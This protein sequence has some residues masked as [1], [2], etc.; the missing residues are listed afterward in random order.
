MRV[1][2]PGHGQDMCARTRCK[3]MQ[4]LTFGAVFTQRVFDVTKLNQPPIESHPSGLPMYRLA[5]ELEMYPS[6]A[7][8]AQSKRFKRDAKRFIRV[9]SSAR[10]CRKSGNLCENLNG[11]CSPDLHISSTGIRK[12]LLLE[13]R[14]NIQE[15]FFGADKHLVYNTQPWTYLHDC[16]EKIFV[17]C[18]C[19]SSSTPYC[20]FS[21]VV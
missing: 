10:F 12:L 17:V 15:R 4:D 6:P 8:L 3:V 21:P 13:K 1:L 5:C 2:C 19:C 16:Y 11:T 18:G 9:I 14:E 7:S 20:P